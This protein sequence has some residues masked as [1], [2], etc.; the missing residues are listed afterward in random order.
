[1]KATL[2]HIA[3]LALLMA[4]GLVSATENIFVENAFGNVRTRIEAG[5]H[6]EEIIK[7]SLIGQQAE[8]LAK[9]LNYSEPVFLDFR[10][11]LF[12]RG[13]APDRFV[14]YGKCRFQRIY[15][16]FRD[17]VSPVF[18]PTD[19]QLVDKKDAVEHTLEV[20]AIVIRQ[21]AGQFDA[22]ATLKLL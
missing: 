7:V 9:Q 15:R 5:H 6:C 17:G 8:Q 16:T 20:D 1:M 2:K 22:E 12:A 3:T 4:H 19:D 13:A 11:T 14:S 18:N 10:H 21:I